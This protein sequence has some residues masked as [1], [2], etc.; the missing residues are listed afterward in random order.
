MPLK[1]AVSSC[2]TNISDSC[3]LIFAKKR[4]QAVI[5]GARAAKYFF[6]S[7]PAFFMSLPA[8]ECRCSFFYQ[9]SVSLREPR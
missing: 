7:N 3:F 1:S 5:E 9:N 6:V 8:H 2:F 4:K